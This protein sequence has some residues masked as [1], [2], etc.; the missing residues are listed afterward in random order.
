M[1]LTYVGHMDTQVGQINTPMGQ[2]NTPVGQVTSVRVCGD[3]YPIVPNKHPCGESNHI[4]SNALIHSLEC[5]IVILRQTL[6]NC[7]CY[8]NNKFSPKS[9]DNTFEINTHGAEYVQLCLCYTLV[10]FYW[11]YCTQQRQQ[12]YWPCSYLQRGT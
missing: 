8:D 9:G 5:I 1:G 12:F 3:E 11:G 6:Y 10:V 2:I 7:A 4:A